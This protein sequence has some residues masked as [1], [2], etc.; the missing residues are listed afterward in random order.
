[1]K[2][3]S[4]FILTHTA[5]PSVRAF[6]HRANIDWAPVTGPTITSVSLWASIH[7]SYGRSSAV[8]RADAQRPNVTSSVPRN[9]HRRTKLFAGVPEKMYDSVQSLWSVPSTGARVPSQVAMS[10]ANALVQ[11]ADVHAV[12]SATSHRYR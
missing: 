11:S 4:F 12:G 8:L 3:T 9:E 2:E 1:M 10:D 7:A 5:H 6:D